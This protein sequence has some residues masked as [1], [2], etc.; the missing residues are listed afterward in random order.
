MKQRLNEVGLDTVIEPVLNVIEVKVKNL[1]EVMKG[2]TAKG[3]HVNP[4]ERLSSFRM[5]MMPHI[6]KQIIDEFIPDL[7][8]VCKEVGEI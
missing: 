3:W 1:K 6:T 7:E 5:V 2:L 8:E 4:V